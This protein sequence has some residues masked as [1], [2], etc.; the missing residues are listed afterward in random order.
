MIIFVRMT[1]L[2]RFESILCVQT[3]ISDNT[4]ENLLLSYYIEN[5]RYIYKVPNLELKS[6]FF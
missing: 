3:L 1:I 2:V 4:M 6:W 5:Q